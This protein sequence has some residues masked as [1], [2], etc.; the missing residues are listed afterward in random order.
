MLTSSLSVS[1]EN[2]FTDVNTGDWYYETVTE[3][4]EK[5]LFEGKG[6]N[7]FCPDDTM[8]VAEFITVVVRALYPDEDITPKAGQK[9]WQG[10]YEVAV[11]NRLM[12]YSEI[13]ELDISYLSGSNDQTIILDIP[14]L[15]QVMAMISVRAL[16]VLGETD[17]QSYESDLIPDYSRVGT[18]YRDYVCKAYGAGI[19]VGDENGNF[20]PRNT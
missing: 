13:I 16:K 14:V 18:Y 2:K 4:T 17:I 6:D 19:I 15:R 3:M 12:D 11:F 10:A 7:L 8:T 1:A 9:W 5:G 20:N